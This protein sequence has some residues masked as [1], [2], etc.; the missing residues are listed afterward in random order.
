[1]DHPRLPVIDRD[2]GHRFVPAEI[3]LHSRGAIKIAD[4]FG[5]EI[6]DRELQVDRWEQFLCGSLGAAPSA[7][8]LGTEIG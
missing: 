7:I 3:L 8:D 6:V 5:F 1:L 2:L 4:A